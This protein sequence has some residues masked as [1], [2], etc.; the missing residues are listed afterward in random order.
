MPLRL[1]AAP[2]AAV[3][4][5]ALSAPPGQ[6]GDFV[7][8]A[9]R[10][11]TLPDRITRVMPAGPTADVLIFVLT[12]EKLVGWSRAPHTNYLPARYARL[13]LSGQLTG[14]NPTATPE[15]VM[16][17]RPDLIV[18]AAAVTPDRAAFAD[19]IQRQ[20]GVPYILVDNSIPRMPAMLRDVGTMLGVAERGEDLAIYAEHAL[21]AIRG[22]LLIQPSDKRP[23]V[24]YARRN[25]GLET[26][27]PGSP[28][29]NGIDEA[30]AINVA[31]AL[32]SDERVLIT[33]EQIIAWNP[34]VVISAQRPFYEQVLRDPAWRQLSAVRNKRVYLTPTSPFG[35]VDEPPGV[36]RLLGL[37][38]QAGLFYPNDLAEDLRTTV[39]EFY[40]KFYRIKLNDKQLE[41]LVKPAEAKY[42]PSKRLASEALLRLETPAGAAPQTGPVPG[43]PPP[44][45][46][47]LMPTPATPGAMPKY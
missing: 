43:L 47:G 36:N 23:R 29:S 30:G 20:T 39:Q 15:T 28:A 40:E 8:S 38:W 2:F 37:F 7:D 11:V 14:P 41:V 27:L 9:G 13:P 25:D 6:A 32:G 17:L 46:R 45:R 44:G 22:Q 33:R 31:G 1:P 26:A 12:P 35:W 34:D 10:R 18:D 4:L 3:L 21:R 42:D 5:L 16:R 24:Y 19:Q